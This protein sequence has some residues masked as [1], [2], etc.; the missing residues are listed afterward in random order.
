MEFVGSSDLA[1]ISHVLLVD[2][3]LVSIEILGPDHR[4]DWHRVSVRPFARRSALAC[5]MGRRKS[6]STSL[7][8]GGL[9][10]FAGE[11]IHCFNLVLDLDCL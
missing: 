11:S 6:S 5:P 2:G 9:D 3:W 10:G 1:K 8:T 4:S 7:A